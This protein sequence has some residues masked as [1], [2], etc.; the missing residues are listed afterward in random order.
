EE[1]TITSAK[2]QEVIRRT[3]REKPD[4]A[5]HWSTRTMA[6]AA[7]LSEKSVRRIWQK[8]DLTPHLS[9]TLR[10]PTIPRSSRNVTAP[11]AD[12]LY[13]A[14]FL[15]L[16]KGPVVL[17]HTNMG[18][19]YFLFP[20][21]DAWTTVIPSA[22]SRTTGEA[23]QNVLIAGPSWHASVPAGMTSHITSTGSRW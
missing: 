15:D 13:S 5:T 4:K 3:T 14:G 23:A 16:T 20:I 9:R 8:H 12:T 19:R 11:N 2:V 10:S 17:T 1:P 7:G 6:E 21:Y 18:K 22:G